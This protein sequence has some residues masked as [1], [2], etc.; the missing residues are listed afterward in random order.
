MK[1]WNIIVCFVSCIFRSFPF[2]VH[3][4][5]L[6]RVASRP[7]QR[8]YP[9]RPDYWRKN[10]CYSN[11]YYYHYHHYCKSGWHCRD[12][13]DGNI[14]DDDGGDD[15]DDDNDGKHWCLRR[16]RDC[17]TSLNH[18]YSHLSRRIPSSCN[19]AHCTV[20]PIS[21]QALFGD[22]IVRRE[23]HTTDWNVRQFCPVQ[24]GL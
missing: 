13:H 3:T 11:R 10:C 8:E 23:H 19:V 1:L 14:D 7:L 16:E 5:L 17:W 18:S 15:A 24:S 9:H 2:C 6:A 4:F 22:T 20:T 21:K 12:G